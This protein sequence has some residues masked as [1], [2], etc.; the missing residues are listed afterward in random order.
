MISYAVLNMTGLVVA[1][2]TGKWMLKQI[3]EY[4]Y[5]PWP[6]AFGSSG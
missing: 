4:A 1:I 2:V 5:F 6:A 3:Y